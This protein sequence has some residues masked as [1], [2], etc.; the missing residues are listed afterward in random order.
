MEDPLVQVQGHNQVHV[1]P[2]GRSVFC[3]LSALNA[4]SLFAILLCSTSVILLVTI[5]Q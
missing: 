1:I 2:E 5:L 3:G 4:F